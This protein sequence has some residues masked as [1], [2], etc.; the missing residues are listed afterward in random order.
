MVLIYRIIFLD[1]GDNFMKSS[2]KYLMAAMAGAG[3]YMLYKKYNP[4]MMMDLKNSINKMSRE[5]S[6]SIENMM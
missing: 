6:K 5:A 1:R 3:A 2:T 4:I